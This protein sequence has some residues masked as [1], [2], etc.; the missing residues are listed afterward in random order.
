MPEIVWIL[1]M[2][3]LNDNHLMTEKDIF[4]VNGNM[5]NIEYLKDKCKGYIS[6]LRG[7]N[8]VSFPIRLYPNHDKERLMK[9][10]GMPTD[11]FGTPVLD[12]KRL[13]FL[14][15]FCSPLVNHQKE[16]YMKV[17]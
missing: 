8:P 1:N 10:P 9:S 4:D 6:Y 15:L 3:L 14:E 16:I 13:S 12:D 2:L 17:K 7:E 11:I 5:N